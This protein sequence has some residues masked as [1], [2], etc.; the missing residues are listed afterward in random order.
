MGLVGL[1]GLG[2]GPTVELEMVGTDAGSDSRS[3]PSTGSEPP[4]PGTSSSGGLEPGT[5]T[6]R[7]SPQVEL[8]P[9]SQVSTAD[10]GELGIVDLDR[11]GRLDVIGGRG[12]V[13]LG[14]EDGFDERVIAGFPV[15]RIA[16]AGQF[17]GGPELDLVGLDDESIY[18]FAGGGLGGA[19]PA[20]TPLAWPASGWDGRDLTGDGIDDL[21][22]LRMGGEVVEIW[23]GT[24]QGTFEQADVIEL[25]APEPLWMVG[26]VSFEPPGVEIVLLDVNRS[27]VVVVDRASEGWNANRMDVVDSQ[28]YLMHSTSTDAGERL[29]FGGGGGPLIARRSFGGVMWREDGTWSSAYVVGEFP[30]PN[31]VAAADFDRD[32]RVDVLLALEGGSIDLHCQSGTDFELCGSTDIPHVPASLTVLPDDLARIVYTTAEDGTWVAAVQPVA[33]CS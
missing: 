5:T 3:V 8:G 2:C 32:G 22:L 6:G 12:H 9:F 28:T 4:R 10:L 15:T 17:D 24:T 13:L 11:D 1:V 25:E 21:A 30:F 31:Q 27:E 19:V 20:S 7:C 33:T 16:H 29:V 26:L 18:V 23:H 14:A